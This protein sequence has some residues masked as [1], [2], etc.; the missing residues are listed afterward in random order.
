MAMEPTDNDV[1]SGRGAWF[2]QHPGNEQFRRMLDEHKT[3]Y[4]AGTKKRKMDISKAIVE[5]IYS[6]DPPGRFLKQCPDTGQWNELS[7]RDAADKAA[8]AMAYAIKGESLKE[9]RKHRRSRRS[10]P[11]GAVA[12][13]SSQSTHRPPQ[14]HLYSHSLNNQL[15]GNVSSS[16]VAHHGLFAAAAAADTNNTELTVS[17]DHTDSVADATGNFN[18][19]QQLRPQLQQS[20]STTTTL[21]TSSS[22]DQNVNQNGLVQVL[23]QAVQQQR[24]HHQ[25]QQAAAPLQYTLGQNPL[26]QQMIPQQ[27]LSPAL[28]EGLTQQILAQAQ[29]QQIIQQ[30]QQQQ[31]QLLLLQR[32]LNQQN[33]L[34]PASLPPPSTPFLSSQGVLPMNAILPAG[35][36]SS[37]N[38]STASQSQ[39]PA[40]NNQILQN[41][42]QQQ[43]LNPLNNALL[44]SSVLNSLQP[45]PIS[46]AGISSN[47][48]QEAQQLDLLQRSLMMQQQQQQSLPLDPLHQAWLRQIQNSQN[49]PPINVQPSATVAA[50]LT[51]QEDSEEKEEQSVSEEKNQH[52]NL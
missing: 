43:Q 35:E 3:A 42:Q 15:E 29:Q 4:M 22:I 50:V 9:K 18:R 20:N 44:L 14:R 23:A 1:L 6:L 38:Q 5:A 2:N 19:R 46:N 45:Q 33:A 51:R 48:P 27:Q 13:K 49:P 16:S 10:L 24:H 7:K 37:T 31:Q 17:N 40:A 41:L 34:P 25:H 12:T 36:A 11:D 21:P 26:G 30:Q 39:Q 32:L 28:L 8:Q 52:S 47:A